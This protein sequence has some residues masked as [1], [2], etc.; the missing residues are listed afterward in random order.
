M[1]QVYCFGLKPRAQG[2]CLRCIVSATITNLRG[3]LKCQQGGTSWV[4]YYVL[5]VVR[6]RFILCIRG[7]VDSATA[8]NRSR[9]SPTPGRPEH[10]SANFSEIVKFL[11]KANDGRA[12]KPGWA[13]LS[14]TYILAKTR[15]RKGSISSHC[16]YGQALC[17]WHGTLL[18]LLL[19]LALFT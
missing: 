2:E 16:L 17:T 9:P 8:L 13:I 12:E 1:N 15:E 4:W 14:A 19:L 11:L 6:S 10:R 18:L 3:R 7:L 5:I